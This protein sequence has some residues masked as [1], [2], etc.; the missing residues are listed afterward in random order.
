MN[1]LQQAAS[2]TKRC[3]RARTI[4]LLAGAPILAGCP[5]PVAHT[6]ATSSPITGRIVQADGA[7]LGGAEIVVSSGWRD[8]ACTQAVARTRTDSAG[9]FQLAKTEKRYGTTWFVPN[10]DRVAPSFTLCVESG[11]ALRDAYE[12]RGSLGETA[13]RDSVECIS[14]EWETS[15]RVSCTGRATQSLVTGGRWVDSISGGEG[16]FRLF[17]TEEPTRVKGYD[18]DKPQNRPHVYVQWV[19]RRDA[20]AG[21]GAE[22]P[23]NVRATVSLPFDRDKV[24]AVDRLQ[25]WRR[26]GRAM[27]SLHGYRHSFMDD[28]ARTEV[29]FELGAPGQATKV[30]GP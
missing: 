28:M 1:I 23:Y 24:W 2:M 8:A 15:P 22:P 25:L 13:E 21:A 7:P 5:I 26:E 12:G 4:L 9:K 30:A 10:L 6:E 29:V 14:W 17:L 11:G 16:F 18:K 27:A 3:I 20:N 19:E